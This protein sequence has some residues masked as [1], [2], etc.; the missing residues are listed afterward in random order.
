R[1]AIVGAVCAIIIGIYAWSANPGLVEL[2]SIEPGESY[3]NLLVKGFRSG[4][5]NMKREVPPGLARLPDP[6]D[7]NAGAPYRMVYGYPLDDLSYYKGKLYLY[8]GVTPALVLFWPYA[9]VTGH[10]LLHETAGI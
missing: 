6:Y 5:L 8:F 1:G 2:L 3:Y 4:Q 9:V 7:K 10:Y